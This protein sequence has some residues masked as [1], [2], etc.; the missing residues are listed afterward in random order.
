MRRLETAVILLSSNEHGVNG[1]ERSPHV[2]VGIDSRSAHS[3]SARATCAIAA[4]V[5]TE[6]V[7]GPKPQRAKHHRITKVCSVSS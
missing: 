3:G 4:T 6:S 5:S 2:R 1:V 7:I